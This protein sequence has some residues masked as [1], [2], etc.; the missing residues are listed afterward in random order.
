[1][2]DPAGVPGAT[3]AGV[4]DWVSGGGMIGLW[5]GSRGVSRNAKQEIWVNV[6]MRAGRRISSKGK[7]ILPKTYVSGIE[8][9][10]TGSSSDRCLFAPCPGK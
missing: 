10:G 1:M 2:Y 8:V 7:A 5:A 3:A 6:R 4:K 9:R